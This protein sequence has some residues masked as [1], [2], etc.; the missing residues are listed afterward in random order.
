[1]K[2]S[3]QSYAR[4]MIEHVIVLALLIGSYLFSG[5]R[6]LG[7]V[8]I[9]TLEVSSAFLQL[10]QVCMY[11]PEKSWWRKPQVV[12]FVHRFLTIPTFV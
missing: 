2:T 4:P 6:R 9:F 3:M 12:I 7:A 1:M 5:L 11:A 10:L 8:G